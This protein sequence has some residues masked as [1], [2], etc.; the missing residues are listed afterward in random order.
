MTEDEKRQRI[1]YLKDILVSAQD[2]YLR[3]TGWAK[4]SQ[5]EIDNV[6]AELIALGEKEEDLN[7]ILDTRL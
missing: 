1:S 7:K 2:N 4:N 5:A 3:Y 6:R